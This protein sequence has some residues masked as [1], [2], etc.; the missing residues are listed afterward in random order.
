MNLCGIIKL[1]ILENFKMVKK[2]ANGI[3]WIYKERAIE[4]CKTILTFIKN[5]V[6]KRY[7][8]IGRERISE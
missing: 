7:M 8:I 2:W 5:V 3:Q 6:M 4:K 1:P